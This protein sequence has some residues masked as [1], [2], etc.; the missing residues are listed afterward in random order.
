MGNP[1]GARQAL[2]R[3]R[4]FFRANL[5]LFEPQQDD[6]V[7]AKYNNKA[8]KTY[9]MYLDNLES[10]ERALRELQVVSR[11]YEDRTVRGPAVESGLKV[12]RFR[13]RGV[14]NVK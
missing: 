7:A 8:R 3:G 10:L 1:A 12:L 14:I 4:D 5:P 13:N 2:L 6:S 9:Q 11:P